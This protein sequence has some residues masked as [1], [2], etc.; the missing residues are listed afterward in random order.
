MHT[1]FVLHKINADTHAALAGIAKVTRLESKQLNVAGTKDKRGVTAQWVTA[2][3]VRL[4][5]AACG[6]MLYMFGAKCAG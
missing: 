1:C 2:F 4:C 6:A 5:G 3:K